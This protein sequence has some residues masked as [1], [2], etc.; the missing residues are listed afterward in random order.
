[1]GALIRIVIGCVV[2]ATVVGG[3]G[4][5]GAAPRPAARPA[6]R[7][8]ASKPVDNFKD[9]VDKVGRGDYKGALESINAALV[10]PPQDPKRLQELF[11]LK[12]TVLIDLRDLDGA[13]AAYQA[14]IDAGAAGANKREALKIIDNLK[15]APPLEITLANG[16]ADIYLDTKSAGVFCTAAPTCSRKVMP[17][18]HKI[19]AERPGFQ[20]GSQR[21]T[22][23]S[24]K[25]ETLAVELVEEP[26][27]LTVRAAQAGAQITVDDAPYTAPV[28]VPGGSHRVAVTLAGHL[29]AHLDAVAHGGVP[30]D[31]DVALD[32]I[33]AVH[34][35]P[36][37]AELVLDGKPATVAAGGIAVSPGAHHLVA[38][39]PGYTERSADLPAELPADYKLELQ[40]P[41]YVATVAP[42]PAGWFTTRRKIAVGAAGVAVAAVVVGAVLGTQAHNDDHD[43][44]ALCP[45]ATTPCSN[46]LKADQLNKDGQS[47]AT[48]AN[49]AFGVAGAGAVAAAVL[50]MIGAPESRVAVAPHV[51][52]V[53]G[54]DLSMR[55]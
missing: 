23:Q 19:V 1:M 9:A 17:G 18:V 47:R 54:L 51:G 52:A 38:R 21:V 45:S 55:F 37:T 28:K 14:Y 31:L 20:P 6:A 13:I 16:P 43:A 32:T 29:D 10:N 46:A 35:E 3:G 22:L 34:V 40:L 39:A 24:G 53:A 26:S 2:L 27:L 5:A 11:Q 33:V 7:P 30:V 49:I 44:F 12:G 4:G 48:Q 25:P 42:A 8:S 41:R 15:A 36:P 50:W